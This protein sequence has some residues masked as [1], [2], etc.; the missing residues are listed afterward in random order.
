MPVV[1]SDLVLRAVGDEILVLDR[2]GERI[3]QLN[4]TASY[5][6]DRCDGRTMVES[7]AQEF[8]MQYGIAVDRASSDI[9]AMLTQLREL[10]L[11]VTN[12]TT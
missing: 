3:H 11:L 6:W 12:I 10:G 5:V 7:V 4:A 8:A 9:R 1:R 2:S